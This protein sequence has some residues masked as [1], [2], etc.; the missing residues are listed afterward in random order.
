M[1]NDLFEERKD[2]KGKPTKEYYVVENPPHDFMSKIIELCDAMRNW[3]KRCVILGAEG[4]Q[5]PFM[6]GKGHNT[7]RN[8]Q[9]NIGELLAQQ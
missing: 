4:S 6:M 5:W 8:H 1:A 7:L 2:A 9:V 3:P